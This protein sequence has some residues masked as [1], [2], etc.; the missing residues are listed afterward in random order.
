MTKVS[1]SPVK[2]AEDTAKAWS[3]ATTALSNAGAAMQNLQD[4][5]AKVAGIVA[6][7]VANIA[8]GFAQASASP[9]TGAAGVFGWIAAATAGLATMTATIASIKSA[10]EYHAEGGIVGMKSLMRG[11]DTVPAML[12]PG[13]VVLNVAQQRNLA[14]GLKGS[15]QAGGGVY[16]SR[17]SGEDILTVLNAWGKRTGRGEVI[18]G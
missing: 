10:T 5:S 18:F 6:Q 12:T 13:E 8:L 11:T 2:V 14:N 17:T 4:P 9:A 16:E 3:A 15:A 7:A 1:M